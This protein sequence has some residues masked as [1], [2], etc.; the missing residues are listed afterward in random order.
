MLLVGR[1]ETAGLQGGGRGER[2]GQRGT[3]AGH[4]PRD[5]EHGQQGRGQP[6]REEQRVGPPG[7]P[8]HLAHVHRVRRRLEG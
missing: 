8:G 2:Q 6:E 1:P 4:E 5:D 3:A 7:V